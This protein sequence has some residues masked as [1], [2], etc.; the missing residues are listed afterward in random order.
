MRDTG[1]DQDYDIYKQIAQRSLEAREAAFVSG[2]LLG[3]LVAITLTFIWFA[4]GW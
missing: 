3:F 1:L 2:F 4:F